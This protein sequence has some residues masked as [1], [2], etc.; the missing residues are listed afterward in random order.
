MSAKKIITV[1]LISF[2]VYL[3][4][5]PF[6]SYRHFKTAL[7]EQAFNHLIT[8][9]DLVK[10]Q[11][12]TYLHFRY[13]DIDT[14]SR[15]PVIAQGFTRLLG[16]FRGYGIESREYQRISNLYQPLMEY[17][18]NDY[19]YTNIVFVSKDSDV[20]FTA[21]QSEFLGS[22]LSTG[23]YKNYTIAQVFKNGLE[24]IAFEDYTWNDELSE[25][26]SYH[27][28][29]VYDSDKLLGVLIIELPFSHFENVLT[30]LS[31]LGQTGE[32]Y[33]VGEDGF[34]RSNS[35]FS[36]EPTMLKVEV[37][38][39]ASRE[40]L[41]GYVGARIIKDYRGVPV[42]SAYTPLNLRFVNWALLVEI[43]E[44]EAFQDIAYVENKLIIIGSIIAT[45]DF[46]Y[47]YFTRKKRDNQNVTEPVEKSKT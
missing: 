19:G 7:K 20:L 25:F 10:L 2:A 26:T 43:D 12:R 41:S 18:V 45:I 40:A 5:V 24:E 39:L 22:N 21:A 23:K 44:K 14:L 47:L 1:L 29:P 28:A 42:L 13:S 17:Y 9:R 11:I 34:M 4:L 6:I 32:M 38:T 27:S 8:A 35:R 37:D 33:L 16:A 36:A 15:N 46:L 30:Q 31:G 3:L